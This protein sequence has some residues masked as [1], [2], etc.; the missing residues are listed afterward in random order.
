MS[1]DED[2]S[3]MS[4]GSADTART[5]TVQRSVSGTGFYRSTLIGGEETGRYLLDEQDQDTVNVMQGKM[6]SGLE[7]VRGS[8]PL[9]LY[10]PI[11]RHDYSFNWVFTE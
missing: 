8:I 3:T 5:Q 7:V 6:Y 4:G 1:S 9:D 10:F 11:T 2:S